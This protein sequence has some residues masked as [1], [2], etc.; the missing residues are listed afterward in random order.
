MLKLI[1]SDQAHEDLYDIWFYIAEDNPINADRFIDK[2]TEK[3][4]WLLEYPNVGINR[5]DLG[6][7]LHSFPIGKYLFVLS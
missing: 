4:Q 1:V 7:G 5:D 2:I 6:S 3:Y